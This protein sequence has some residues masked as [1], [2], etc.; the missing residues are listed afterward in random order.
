MDSAEPNKMTNKNTTSLDEMYTKSSIH[1]QNNHKGDFKWHTPVCHNPTNLKTQIRWLHP[2]CCSHDSTE[3]RPPSHLYKELAVMVHC[4]SKH[5]L[6]NPQNRST[7]LPM[8][9]T[10]S[11][12][13]VATRFKEWT[14]D[15][16]GRGAHT[17]ELFLLK[18]L[19]KLLHF[20]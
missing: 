2:P 13:T 11:I 3:C 4:F 9:Y 6:Y 20:S 10:Y 8:T 1:L 15:S 5:H 19:S 16:Q 14:H 12:C 7:F 17:P 18:L